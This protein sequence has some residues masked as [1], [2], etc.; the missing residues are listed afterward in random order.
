MLDV[1]GLL[2]R[3]DALADFHVFFGRLI[4]ARSRIEPGKGRGS[5]TAQ[6]GTEYTH[7]DAVHDVHVFAAERRFQGAFLGNFIFAV[8]GI[9]LERKS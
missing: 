7:T 9:G 5:R 1:E 2:Q 4:P 3:L 6:K 8:L